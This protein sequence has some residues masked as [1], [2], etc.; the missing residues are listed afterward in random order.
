MN[1]RSWCDASNKTA[2]FLIYATVVKLALLLLNNYFVQLFLQFLRAGFQFPFMPQ[3][4]LSL[5]SISLT[6]EN[7]C[8]FRFLFFF[9]FYISY[10]QLQQQPGRFADCQGNLLTNTSIRCKP[11]LILKD[12]FD[13]QRSP[14]GDLSSLPFDNSIYI[15]FL[16]V[17]ILGSLYCIRFSCYH[18]NAL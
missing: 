9:S 13:D 4:M 3:L 16:Y 6:T 8:Q 5:T 10:L 11:F 15:T 12:F 17:H 14:A 1:V 7:S 2:S 18:L